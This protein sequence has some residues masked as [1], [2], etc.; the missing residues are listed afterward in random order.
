M[1][2]IPWLKLQVE[3]KDTVG[4]LAR[5]LVSDRCT[6]IITGHHIFHNYL[7]HKKASDT[8]IGALDRALREYQQEKFGLRRRVT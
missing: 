7:I 3:R 1:N 6:D 8:T 5:E 4:N 2:F